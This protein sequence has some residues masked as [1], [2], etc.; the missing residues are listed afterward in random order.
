MVSANRTA[1]NVHVNQMLLAD[2]VID[3]EQDTGVFLIVDRVHVQR[4]FVMN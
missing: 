2:D 3:V 4:R 1:V